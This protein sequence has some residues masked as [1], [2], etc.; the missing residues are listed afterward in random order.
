VFYTI[1]KKILTRVSPNLPSVYAIFAGGTGLI[2]QETSCAFSR[3][4]AA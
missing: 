4:M 1:F 3:F 2:F